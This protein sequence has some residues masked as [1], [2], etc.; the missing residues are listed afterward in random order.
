M[1]SYAELSY[2]ESS[3]QLLQI[4]EDIEGLYRERQ[5][6]DMKLQKKLREQAELTEKNLRF[7][8]IVKKTTNGSDYYSPKKRGVNP[9]TPKKGNCTKLCSFKT[10]DKVCDC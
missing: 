2:M 10:N 9:P 8:K 4:K 7:I 3:L 1:D 5:A 6:I